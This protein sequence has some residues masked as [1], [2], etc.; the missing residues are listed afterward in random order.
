MFLVQ[1]VYNVLSK[2]QDILLADIH[3]NVTMKAIINVQMLK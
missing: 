1:P 3:L 2:E